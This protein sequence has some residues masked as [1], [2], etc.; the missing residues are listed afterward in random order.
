MKCCRKELP[1]P[2]II[3]GTAYFVCPECGEFRE[4]KSYRVY[5]PEESL[6]AFEKEH[7]FKIPAKYIDYAGT[8]SDHVIKLPKN[9]P[10]TKDEYFGD[11]FYEIGS[12]L[13]LDHNENRSI[14]DS[15]WLVREWGLPERLVLI[16][17]DG[18]EW[19]ALDYRNSEVEP[20][21]ILIESEFNQYKVVANNFD[22]FV[23]S[24]IPYESVYDINGNLIYT[25]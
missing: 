17:G 19:L 15:S 5:T 7:G 22:D 24:L 12:Y 9:T 10:C 8:H 11:G 18:H 2:D 21:V 13:G 14:F 4:V 23:D 25:G 6:N 20:R 1:K 16:E 3:D